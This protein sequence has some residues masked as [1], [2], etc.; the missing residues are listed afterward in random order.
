[1]IASIFFMVRRIGQRGLSNA[2]AKC[3]RE[4]FRT[5]RSYDSGR[6]LASAKPVSGKSFTRRMSPPTEIG[7]GGFCWKTRP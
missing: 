2:R 5:D 4:F 6:F 1:M 7:T 3:G